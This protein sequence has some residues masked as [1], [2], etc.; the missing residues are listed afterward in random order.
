MHELACCNNHFVS[1]NITFTHELA[2]LIDKSTAIMIILLVD[3]SRKESFVGL[4]FWLLVSD[5]GKLTA[6]LPLLTNPYKQAFPQSCR[7]H[8]KNALPT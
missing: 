1:K 5:S 8:Y 7:K 4:L 3:T 6:K 2:Q